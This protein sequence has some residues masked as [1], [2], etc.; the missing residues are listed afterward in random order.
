MSASDTTV[1]TVTNGTT[2]RR[3]Q[4]EDQGSIFVMV[5]VML[6]VGSLIVLPLMAYTTSVFRAGSVQV[7]KTEAVERA[8]GGVWVAL[9]NEEDLY[10]ENLCNGTNL[11][12]SMP[13]VTTTC[14][15]ID[16]NLLRP[17]AEIPYHVVTLKADAVV[18]P[19]FASADTISPNTTPTDW[20]AWLTAPGVSTDSSAGMIWVPDLPVR[21]TT[22]SN[23]DTFLTED[24][25]CRLFFPGTFTSE[26]HIDG[27]AYFA[28]GVYYFEEPINLYKGADV[29]VGYG[30]EPGCVADDFLAIAG[31]DTSPQP[32]NTAGW[33]GTLVL[34]DSA[35]LV[36]DDT[37]GPGSSIR[38]VMNQRYVPE[39]ETSVLTSQNVSITSV[40]GTHDPL[41]AP[42]VLGDDLVIADVIHVPASKVDDGDTIEPAVNSGY[43]PSNLTNKPGTPDAPVITL[44][45]DTVRSDPGGD[46]RVVVE[47][48]VPNDNGALITDYVVRASGLPGPDEFCSPPAVAPGQTLQNT[49]RIRNIYGGGSGEWVDLE[50]TAINAYGSSAPSAQVSHHVE[51]ATAIAAQAPTPPQNPVVTRYGDGVV[52]SWDPSADDGGLPITEYRV[53][54]SNGVDPD[55]SCTAR[56]DETSCPLLYSAGLLDGPHYTVDVIAVQPDPNGSGGPEFLSPPAT[57]L[58]EVMNATPGNGNVPSGPPPLVANGRIPDPILD[59]RTTTSTPTDIK[60]EGYVVLPQ[61]RVAID[62]ADPATMSLEMLG[63]A[64]AGAIDLGTEPGNL[65]VKLDNP[66]SQKRVLIEATV[67]SPYAARSVAIVQ[68]NRSGSIA[69][70]SWFVQ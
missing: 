4:P 42:E 67:A 60:I 2:E 70:N 14:V 31:A 56:W 21:H 37:S 48:S 54:V 20:A 35:K 51:Y 59:L 46:G 19:A 7:D 12:G 65:D 44:T 53:M 5:L 50:V 33:G 55:V 13:G 28:S 24:P 10:H 6:V 36:I 17:L 16:E 41:V 22:S 9:S 40:N 8:R 34:G 61:G 39:D 57:L 47:W 69:V 23:R 38:F 15:V 30:P 49:C 66:V 58:N 1:T 18:P 26:I 64:V 29:V 45:E 62:A 52:V 27:P 63:G 25:T 32:H 11:S 3:Q 43:E 68:L